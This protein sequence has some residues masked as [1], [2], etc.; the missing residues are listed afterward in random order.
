M[1]EKRRLFYPNSDNARE[2]WESNRTFPEDGGER[3]TNQYSHC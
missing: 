2:E 1:S 3:I